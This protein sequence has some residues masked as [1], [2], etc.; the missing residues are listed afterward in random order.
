MGE[1]GWTV[2][3]LG[4]IVQTHIDSQPYPPTPRQVARAIGITQTALTNWTAHGVTRLPTIENLQALARVTGTPYPEIL[5]A[6]L[7]DAGYLTE[8]AIVVVE[9]TQPTPATQ[10]NHAA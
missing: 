10:K 2:S 7:Q 6:A 3:Q 4:A 9:Q 5:T 8:G 1:K